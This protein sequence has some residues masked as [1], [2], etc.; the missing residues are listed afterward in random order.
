MVQRTANIL[1]IDVSGSTEEDIS[2]TD[3]RN[4]L[5]GE[6]E[7]ATMFISSLPVN[8]Y[9]SL[10]TFDDPS[11]VII[12]LQPLRQKLSA[13]RAVQDCTIGGGTGMRSALNQAYNQ[14]RNAPSGYQK[15]CYCVTDGMAT[16]GDCYEIAN[17][18][19]ESGVQLH[20]I[21]FGYGSEIDE[22]LMMSLAST[23][24]TEGALYK[25]FSSVQQFSRF[26]RT[27]TQT[28]TN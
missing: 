26:M 6:K 12:P 16:D 19:K 9:F 22:R 20:F 18:L 8:T 14:F 2:P 5:T 7:A 13:I 25:H 15:R 23:S 4:K 21:G 17:W 24:R 28:I 11:N 1:L 10:I 27:Q 3:R